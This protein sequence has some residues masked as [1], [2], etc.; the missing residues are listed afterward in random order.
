MTVE[1]AMLDFI[2]NAYVS[3]IACGLQDTGS[4]NSICRLP[5]LELTSGKPLD[6]VALRS[7]LLLLS[8]VGQNIY[9]LYS[10][11]LFCDCTGKH[12][13]SKKPL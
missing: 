1:T 10:V 7:I 11:Y 2:V 3:V 5:Y 13:S 12:R 9:A 6:S 8:F 4:L